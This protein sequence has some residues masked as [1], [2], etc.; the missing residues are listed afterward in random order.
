MLK[1]ILRVKREEVKAIKVERAEDLKTDHRSFYEAL[2]KPNRTVGLIAEIKKASPSKGVIKTSFDH[3]QI[4]RSYE[5]GGADCLSVLTDETFFQGSKSYIRQVKELV[6]LPVLRKD[7]IIDEKQIVESKQIGA[8]AILLIAEALTPKKL[9][10]MYTEAKA[11]N[12]DV[13]VEVHS[14]D[15]LQGV[16]DQFVPEMIG[17]NNRDLTTFDTSIHHTKEMISEI[18]EDVLIVSESGI[19][20]RQDLDTVHSY[21]ANAVLVGESLMKKPDQQR[22]I[23]QLFGEESNEKSIR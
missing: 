14:K 17:I 21:G 18:R 8:D 3:R 9:K 4:A 11:L 6:Q 20:T 13:L 12:L 1:E 7:F 19:F 22:A 23:Y 10:K 2:K 15:S 16:L 5:N